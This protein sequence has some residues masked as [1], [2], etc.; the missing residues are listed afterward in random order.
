MSSRK[1]SLSPA[2]EMEKLMK[3]VKKLHERVQAASARMQD[4]DLLS[5]YPEIDLFASVDKRKC[6]N[7]ILW[8]PLREALAID[9][10]TIRWESFFYAFP[11]SLITKTLSKIKRDRAYAA[12]SSRRSVSCYFGTAFGKMLF[13]GRVLQD[14]T[15]R[16][17]S[18]RCYFEALYDRVFC[19]YVYF[20]HVSR[21][22]VK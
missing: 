12:T 5:G 20:H 14:V 15:S 21:A 18:A 17:R 3:K 13:R 16:P 10:F 2:R 4:Q 6:P 19:G 7:F 8:K 11:L 9:A 1:R 22:R